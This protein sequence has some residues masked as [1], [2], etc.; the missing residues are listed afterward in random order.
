M[1]YSTNTPSPFS[2]DHAGRR[3]RV[4]RWCVVLCGRQSAYW[5][6]DESGPACANCKGSDN[7]WG[8]KSTSPVGSFEANSFGLFDTAGNVREWVADCW[9]DNYNGAPHDGGVWGE[10]DGSSCQQRVIRSG[11]WSYFTGFLRSSNRFSYRQDGRF[12]GVGIRLAQGLLTL[13]ALHFYPL[14]FC[15]DYG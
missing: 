12:N 7:D 13:R 2:L 8:G 6:G 10:A 4:R 11:S 1:H 14:I 5:W 15:A 3:A 9:H